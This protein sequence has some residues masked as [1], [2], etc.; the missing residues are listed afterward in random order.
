MLTPTRWPLHCATLAGH[1]HRH[2]HPQRSVLSA[3]LVSLLV[4]AACHDQGPTTGSLRITVNT[5]GGDLDLDGYA[6]TIDAAAPQSIAVTGTVMLPDLPTG[7]HVIELIGLAANCT[8]A[9]QNPRSVTVRGG[10]T[11][12]VSFV[13]SCVAT[14][15]QITTPTTGADVDPD[16]FTVAV[17]DAAPQSIGVNGVVTVTRLTAGSHTIDL[18]GIATNCTVAAPNPRTVTIA[19]GEVAP[20]VL[21]VTCVATTG[22]IEVTT[23]TV[24]IDLDA[25]G[26]TVQLDGGPAQALGINGTA[27][28]EGLAGGDHSVSFAGSAGNCSIAG[29]NPRTLP[30]SI[31]GVKRDTVRTTF[32]VT[33]VAVTGNIQV[34]TATSGIDLDPS[35]YSIKVDGG[36]PR[37]ILDNGLATIE[38]LSAGDHT[39]TL[40]NAEANCAVAGDNP[41]TIHVVAGGV[42]RDTARTT[43]QVTCVAVTGSIL[44][45]AATTGIDLDPNGYTV[46]VDGGQLRPLPLNGTVLI[47]GLAGGDHSLGFSGAAAN[48]P[49]AGAN[50]RTVHVTTGGTTRDT[51][52][53][54][55]DV[56]CVAVTGTVQVTTTVSGVDPDPNGFSA[57]LDDGQ[58]RPVVYNGS[59]LFTG[60]SAGDHSVVLFDLASNCTVNG[61]NQQTVHVTT[62]GTTRDTARTSFQ[63][64]CVAVEKIAFER[65]ANIVVAYADGSNA[66]QFALGTGPT[67][68]PDGTKIAYAAINC[69]YYY[70]Y[71]CYPVGIS[72]QGLVQL[73]SNPSDLQ[74]AWSP[75]GTKIAFTSSRS[76]RPGLWVISAAGGSAATLITDNPRSVSEPAWSPDGTQLAFTCLVDTGNTDICRIN[77]NGT[78]FVRLTS[79][80]AYDAGPAWKPGSS[81]IAFATTRYGGG[82]APELAVMNADGGGVARVS[83]GTAAS[84]PAWSPDGTKL[85][86]VGVPSGLQVM[87]AD[88]TGITRLTSSADYAPAWRP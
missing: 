68:S 60:V 70:D 73:T 44:V 24:G 81:T 34:T 33:C 26:Y 75:D 71:Y 55:F 18:G 64:T 3:Y 76:G 46:L 17:D 39:V 65:D 53:T 15:F 38:G 12:D 74:P 54:T 4:A 1:L 28:F 13:V 23:A 29:D 5:T 87:N 49:V 2:A 82:G 86:F 8:V 50:P 37:P 79:D 14:G 67:W 32:Q 45:T 77:A 84:D 30:V 11:V 10:R 20:V 31:G 88:G 57:L 27:R 36:S 41:R 9:A 22:N 51:A 66:V 80:P 21:G 43:F 19:T 78:G 7:A 16:G 40:A 42:T 6:L 85:V 61:P 47:E 62:G 59:V 83:P 56:T 69:D 48:C 72:V 35:G 52:R 58:S 63:V 25:D